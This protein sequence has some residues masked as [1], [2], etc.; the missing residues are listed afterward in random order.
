LIRQA[1]VY[2]CPLVEKGETDLA[3]AQVYK[4]ELAQGFFK[5]Y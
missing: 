1:G 4:E 5:G 2:S 3:S